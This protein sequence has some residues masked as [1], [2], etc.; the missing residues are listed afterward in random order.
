LLELE[1]EDVRGFVVEPLRDGEE[2][3]EDGS[4]RRFGGGFVGVDIGEF[5][6]P[7]GGSGRAIDFRPEGGQG[8]EKG[9]A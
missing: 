8:P 5:E 1:F 2:P 7:D 6:T 4:V 9:S 3:A